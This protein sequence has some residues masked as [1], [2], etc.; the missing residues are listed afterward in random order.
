MK[1]GS[2]QK[3]GGDERD[4]IIV[5]REHIDVCTGIRSLHADFQVPVYLIHFM[6]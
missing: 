6:H 4:A 1:R 2:Q 3:R 5:L